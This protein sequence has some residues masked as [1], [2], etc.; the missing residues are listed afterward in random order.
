MLECSVSSTVGLN[1]ECSCS[2]W[3]CT[4][5]STQCTGFSTVDVEVFSVQYTVLSTVGL[6]SECS[7]GEWKSVMLMLSKH[8]CLLPST[9]L[10]EQ[11]SCIVNTCAYLCMFHICVCLWM[12]TYVQQKG[13]YISYNFFFV[14]GCWSLP[15]TLVERVTAG[16]L[17]TRAYK[18]A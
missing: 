9:M 10:W 17:T 2:E 5:N 18:W 4:C 14:V 3:N 1:N 15:V 16:M 6:N 12:Y 8:H 11:C 7:S 13:C